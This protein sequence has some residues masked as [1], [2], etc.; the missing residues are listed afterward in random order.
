M[1]SNKACDDQ[2]S[3]SVNLPSR[4]RHASTVSF[5]LVEISE[6]DK[7]ILPISETG[8]VTF[9]RL[10]SQSVFSRMSVNSQEFGLIKLGIGVGIAVVVVFVIFIT[11]YNWLKSVAVK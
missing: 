1:Q 2:S 4:L 6:E 9:K 5:D 3:L 8:T 7:D 10:R 11:F